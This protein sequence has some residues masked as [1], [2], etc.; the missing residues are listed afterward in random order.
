[1]RG[2]RILA[3][4]AFAAPLV[5][6]AGCDSCRK[7]TPPPP[8]P[9]PEATASQQPLQL[10]SEDAAVDAPAEAEASAPKHGAVAPQANLKACCAALRQ[11]SH[12]VTPPSS[13][14]MLQA[15]AACDAAVAAGK[16][17][18]SILSI[19]QAALKT[20]KMPAACR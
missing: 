11:N 12:S 18:G 10:P 4:I 2:G 15:A 5:G 1:M 3:A 19:V 17:K 9:A 16:S 14:Y 7:S 6:A 8:L 20:A 13:L